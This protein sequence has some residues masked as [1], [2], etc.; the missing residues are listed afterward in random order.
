MSLINKKKA[1]EISLKI[2]LLKNLNELIIEAIDKNKIKNERE[3][4]FS[5][6]KNSIYNI[7][8]NQILNNISS[9]RTFAFPSSIYGHRYG[10]NINAEWDLR[11]NN[12]TDLYTTDEN[13]FLKNNLNDESILNKINY[14]KKKNWN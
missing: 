5:Y 11:K 12:L 14:A 10:K 6:Y 1:I 9:A 7:N 13:G 8:N 4:F 2:P 3:K